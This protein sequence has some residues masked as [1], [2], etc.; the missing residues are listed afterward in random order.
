MKLLSKIVIAEATLRTDLNKME[1]KG[2]MIVEQ[3]LIILL[4]LTFAKKEIA[5][6]TLN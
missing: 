4:A 1:S 2:I 5:L 6:K 3:F